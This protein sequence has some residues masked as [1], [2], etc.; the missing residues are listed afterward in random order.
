LFNSMQVL[1]STSAAFYKFCTSMS[2]LHLQQLQ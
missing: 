1:H 2:V